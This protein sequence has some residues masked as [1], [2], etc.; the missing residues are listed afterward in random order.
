[1]KK[2]RHCGRPNRRA[3]KIVN[4]RVSQWKRRHGI[5]AHERLEPFDYLKAAYGEVFKGKLRWSSSLARLL[6]KGAFG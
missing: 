4:L 6:V 5:P 1:M 2:L 3:R